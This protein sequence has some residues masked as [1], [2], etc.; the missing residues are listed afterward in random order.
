M[1]FIT[2][3]KR[4]VQFTGNS[5]YIVSLPIK[6]VRDIGLEAGCT[7]NLTPIPNKTLLI[8]SNSNVHAVP[9]ANIEYN[10]S[11]SAEN[12][13]R[14]LISHYLAGYDSIRLTTKK[15]SVPMTASSSKTPCVRK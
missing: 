11:D 1:I 9:R 12:N 15:V 3:D 4:K 7:L 10:H 14:I 2:K 5:T 13:F 8:S 6:W